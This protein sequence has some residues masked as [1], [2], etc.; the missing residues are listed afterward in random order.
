L[1]LEIVPVKLQNVSPVNTYRPSYQEGYLAGKFP[2]R[3]TKES[4]DNL[5]K[6]LLAKFLLNNHEGNFW[7]IGFAEMPGDLLFPG[8]DPMTSPTPQND[9][10][11]PPHQYKQVSFRLQFPFPH[12]WWLW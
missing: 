8:D 1:Y 11:I 3:E 10:K 6:R 9:T 12:Q 2:I 5:A 4:G 7:G